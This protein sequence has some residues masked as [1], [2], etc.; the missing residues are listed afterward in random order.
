MF[1]RFRFAILTFLTLAV[2]SDA[3][4]QTNTCQVPDQMKKERKLPGVR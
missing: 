2:V 3:A 4:A 1:M